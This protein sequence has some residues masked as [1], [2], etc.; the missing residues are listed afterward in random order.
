MLIARTA[1]ELAAAT[2]ALIQ[3]RRSLT[4]VPTMGALHDGH[5]AL[6]DLAR[7]QG[8]AA[9][10]SIFVNPT[11]FGASEDLA[12]YPRDEA[13][14][15]DRLRG[16]GC[17]LAWLP[18]AD[19]IY[20]PGDTT[21]IDP[22]GPAQG[23]EGDLRP[24]HFRGVATV[25]AKLFGHVRPD[26]AVFGEKDWQQL[27]VIRRITADLVLPVQILAAPIIRDTDGL[28]L[29]S[30]NRFL[31][32]AE[33]RAAPALYR[34][35]HTA[36]RAIAAASPVPQILSHARKSLAEAGMALEYLALVDGATLTELHH[37]QTGARLI[38]AARLGNVRLLDNVAA[39]PDIP[40]RNAL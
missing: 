35:L 32:P 15:L 5:L 26:A 11:Q 3:A 17:D 2:A 7:A 12:R 37:A 13:G 19:A 18:Q 24:G 28:A 21:F 20:P 14:D 16:A 8:G 4:L 33:R 6:L 10:A 23:W 25:V 39:L 36:S 40:G 9:I 27:Q 31:S 1:Q 22:S 30:R 34:A 38:A 29:S